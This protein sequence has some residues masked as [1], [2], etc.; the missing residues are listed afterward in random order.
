MAKYRRGD[1]YEHFK[2]TSSIYPDKLADRNET[3][4][5]A[6]RDARVKYPT[7]G[8]LC[9]GTNLV[10]TNRAR[11]R[12]N[13]EVNNWLA[14]FSNVLV[15]APVSWGGNQR[16]ANQPQDMKIWEGIVLMAR[17]NGT[18]KIKQSNGSPFNLQNGRRYQVVS[19]AV[20]EDDSHGSEPEFEMACINDKNEKV[21]ETF[22]MSKQDLAKT[23]RLTYA[24][25]YYSSQARTIRGA[26]R[27]CDTDHRHFSLRHLIVGLGRAPRG[28]VVQVE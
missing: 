6:L 1:D 27:L 2:F 16:D 14:P 13:K 19:I 12:I 15:K 25:T 24:F 26:L 23:M 4:Q 21:S 7:K 28:D 11:I 22:M 20:V 9:L 8:T 3:V 5:N 10:I 18:L 17:V